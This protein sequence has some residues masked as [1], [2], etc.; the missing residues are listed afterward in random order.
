MNWLNIKEI[1]TNALQN[2]GLAWWV[3]VKTQS[4]RCTYYFGPFLSATNAEAAMKGYVEDLEGE[5]AQGILVEVK[6]C[7]PNKLTVADDLGESIDRK[8]QPVFSGQ[9]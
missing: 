8:V 4:P 2:L 7:K 9:F 5:G 6:R 3:E 1:S